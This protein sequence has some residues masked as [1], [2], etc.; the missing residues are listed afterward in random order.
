M[1]HAR[2]VSEALAD[3]GLEKTAYAGAALGGLLGA[4]MGYL[5]DPEH[6][7][8]AAAMGGLG[9]AAVGHGVGTSMNRGSRAAAIAHL[10]DPSKAPP[11]GPMHPPAPPAAPPPAAAA[12]KRAP[13]VRTDKYHESEKLYAKHRAQMRQWQDQLLEQEEAG[14]KAAADYGLGV[15]PSGPSLSAFGSPEER[16]PGMHR[17]VP[18]ETI[19]NVYKQLDMGVDPADVQTDNSPLKDVAGG[20]V[21]GGLAGATLGRTPMWG[22]AGAGIGAAAGLGKHL[23]GSKNRRAE[24]QEALYGVMRERE[25]ERGGRQ[26]QQNAP[27]QDSAREAMPLTVATNVGM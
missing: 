13:A 23:L 26:P 14:R 25:A 4:G 9:G 6:S 5:A 3:F 18:R 21:L 17:W 20:G 2:G 24:T 10:S 1:N 22:L 11:G 27:V 16:L 7:W 8:Q 19:E 12:P 15:G